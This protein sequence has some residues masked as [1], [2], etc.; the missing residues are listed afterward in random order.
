MERE[1]NSSVSGVQF[2]LL[3]VALRVRQTPPLTAPANRM[4]ASVGCG[5][6]AWME[7][8]TSLFGTMFSTWPFRV[9]PGPCACQAP[10]MAG[11]AAG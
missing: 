9:G 1:D 5:A 11:A 6:S 8:A 4:L 3:A 2:G 10:P 7:P